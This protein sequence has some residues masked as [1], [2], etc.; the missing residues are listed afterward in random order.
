M[1]DSLRAQSSCGRRQN[2]LMAD[3]ASAAKKNRIQSGASRV[4]GDITRRQSLLGHDVSRFR[5]EIWGAQR[6]SRDVSGA[7]TQ[8][9]RQP[10][11]GR[12]LRLKAP[13]N[14]M[15]GCR[16]KNADRELSRSSDLLARTEPLATSADSSRRDKDDVVARVVQRRDS[17][18]ELRHLDTRRKAGSKRR[19]WRGFVQEDRSSYPPA[20]GGCNSCPGEG[21]WTF[22]PL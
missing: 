19:S 16:R 3:K 13:S 21:G 11:S 1:A 10:N 2:C 9:E 20:T 18:A 6:V 7:V 22:Q 5:L 4:S 14:Q 15:Q 12:A 17:F 8:K